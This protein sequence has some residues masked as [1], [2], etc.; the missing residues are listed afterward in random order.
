M[1]KL[2][3]KKTRRA[4]DAPLTDAELKTAHRLQ[5]KELA[6]MQEAVR[7]GRP[8]GRNKEVTS[9]SFDADVLMQLRQ[10]KGWQTWLNSLAKAALGIEHKAK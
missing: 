5:G 4:D 10:H 2:L 7:R 6:M 9:V 3:K 8:S 1:K